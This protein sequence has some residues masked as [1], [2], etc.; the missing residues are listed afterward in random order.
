[1]F[2]FEAHQKL[3]TFCM[4]F[5]PGAEPLLGTAGEEGIRLWDL[6]R[7]KMVHEISGHDD[8]VSSLAFSPDGRQLVACRGEHPTVVRVWDWRQDKILFE[9]DGMSMVQCAIFSPDGK[10]LAVAGYNWNGPWERRNAIRRFNLE[11]GGQ[12]R[13]LLG[14]DQQVGFLDYSPDGRLLASG[15]ADRQTILWDLKSRQALAR[16]THPKIVWGIA[17]SPDGQ[18]LA[19]TGGSTIKL[20]DVPKRR[21]RRGQLRGHTDTVYGLAF[22]ADSRTLASVGGDGTVRLWDITSR[23]ARKVLDWGLGKMHCVGFSPD[24]LLAAAGSENGTIVVWDLD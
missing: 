24:G 5:V 23:K 7:R 6:A 22:A 12:R 4:A 3:N 11:T 17:F 15:A 2:T 20:I 8:T 14:H 21:A 1:M 9:Y 19:T 18:T 16:F 10:D 13:V